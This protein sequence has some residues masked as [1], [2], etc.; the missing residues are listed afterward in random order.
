MTPTIKK[1]LFME[2]DTP[3]SK[4]NKDYNECNIVN[5]FPN[6]SSIISPTSTIMDPEKKIHKRERTIVDSITENNK[7]SNGKVEFV[8]SFLPM[9]D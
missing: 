4:M 1:D 5:L 8:R 6:I 9:K 3:T 7:R 2:F